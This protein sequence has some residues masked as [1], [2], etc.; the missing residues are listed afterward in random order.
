MTSSAG[1]MLLGVTNSFQSPSMSMFDV[2]ES[3]ESRSSE[4][5]N[6]MSNDSYN[7][8]QLEHV[9]NLKQEF[10]DDSFRTSFGELLSFNVNFDDDN[11]DG[12]DDGNNGE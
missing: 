11:G 6:N 7:F 10:T 4:S 1:E 3:F 2:F 9:S 8:A 12:D 5:D